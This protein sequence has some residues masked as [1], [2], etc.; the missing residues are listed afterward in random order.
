MFLPSRYCGTGSPKRSLSSSINK[1]EPIF[2]WSVLDHQVFGTWMYRDC[3]V[4]NMELK[5]YLQIFPH[6]SECWKHGSINFQN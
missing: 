3:V 4:L 2:T 6:K 5:V 1:G